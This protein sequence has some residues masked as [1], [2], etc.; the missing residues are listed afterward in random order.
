MDQPQSR[1]EAAL[2]ARYQIVREVGSGGMATVY[3]AEDLRHHRKVAVKVLRPELAATMGP[4]RFLHEIQ[5]AAG[6][7]HP[8]IL[9]LHDSGEA[10]GFLY[11]VMPYV[12]GQTLRDRLTR[13]GELPI[14]AAVKILSEVVDALVAAHAAGVI[15]R[16]IKPEN[17]MLSGRH[18]LVTDFGVAKAVNEAT[19][20]H[21]LTTAGVAL[22][23]PTYMAPEQA[24]AEPNLDHRVDIYAVGVMA[25][26]LLTG[27]PP[28]SGGAQQILAAH[29]TQAP[30][31]VSTHRPSLPAPLGEVVMKCLAKR[32]ADR[33]ETAEQLLRAL[34]P[35]VTPSGGI[36]PT[37]T[38]PLAAVAATVP[39]RARIA[40]IGI[41]V[42]TVAIGAFVVLRPRA[43]E[44][45]TFGGPVRVT[46]DE[47]L[48]MDPA[49]S[50]DGK[51][52]AFA[53][54]PAAAMKIFVR[55]L[56]GGTAVRV[57]MELSGS[58]RLPRWSPD[59]STLLFST[60]SSEPGGGIYAVPALGGTP[61]VVVPPVKD[62]GFAFPAWSPDGKRIAYVRSV[63][64]NVLS[65][66]WL[67]DFDGGEPRQLAEGLE[68]HSLTW[69]PD[70]KWIAFVS[71][72]S[73]YQFAPCLGQPRAQ[74]GEAG[75]G[76]G[77]RHRLTHRRQVLT[78]QSD[79]DARREDP[80]PGIEPGGW[81]GHLADRGGWRRACPGRVRTPHHRVERGRDRFGARWPVARLHG[82]HQH[83]EHLV[84]RDSDR[85]P[86]FDS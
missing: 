56:S 21:Q 59:G 34:E 24:A 73:R 57:T 38:R 80:A 54:G 22:G 30:Q 23:T 50:P 13:E 5:I 25:Y 33:W 3:L 63:G 45:I 48:E 46:L 44:R 70:A 65:T 2:A 55:A 58:H 62:E 37:T 68:F 32:P 35:L 4:Q 15:H 19:G 8:H 43:P 52:V 83:R 60:N 14:P 81:S 75:S 36:T 40:G 77:R 29:V 1:L 41:A 76:G 66:L 11:Y 84:D 7:Q 12:E 74:H 67:R 17:V 26:E 53:A 47:G 71:G 49:I 85:Q 86:G 42:L 27:R 51:M 9:P 69:S 20:R 16:D 18:A 72:N 39:R 28:F 64:A 10:D 6:L 82:L 61:R 31:P 78:H 79:V